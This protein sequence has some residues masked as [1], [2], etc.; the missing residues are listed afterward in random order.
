[1]FLK[2]RD[3]YLGKPDPVDTGSQ[4]PVAYCTLPEEQQFVQRPCACGCDKL[5]DRDFPPGHDVRAMQQRVSDHFDGLRWSSSSGST[6]CSP[7]P[8]VPP[9]TGRRDGLRKAPVVTPRPARLPDDRRRARPRPPRPPGRFP[10]AGRARRK[11]TAGVR[12]TR[13]AFGAVMPG[14]V[15]P[16]SS[17]AELV[18]RTGLAQDASVVGV[19]EE[20]FHTPRQAT[21]KREPHATE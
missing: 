8:L 18:K 5:T 4:N 19:F 12:T 15:I 14:E 6:T 20:A 13:S 1:M 11:R 10:A 17:V 21:G 2:P 16:E 9:R 7:A 3:A